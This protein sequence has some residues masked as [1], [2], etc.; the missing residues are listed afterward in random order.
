MTG[1]VGG[2]ADDRQVAEALD[3]G[4]R[5][6]VERVARGGL[7][8]ADAAFAEDHVAVALGHDVLGGQEPL[9][10]RGREAA[11]EHDR[12]ARQADFVE[13]HEVLHV[14]RADLQDVGVARDEFDVAGFHDLGDH[15]QSGLLTG[16]RQVLQT[17]LAESAEG[18]GRGARFEGAAAQHLGAG[19][20][21]GAG[22]RDHVLFV[23]DRAG[24]GHHDHGA[25]ADLDAVDVDDGVFL[26]EFA[27]GQL[28]GPGDRDDLVDAAHAAHLGADVGVA[29]HAHGADHDAFLTR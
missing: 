7:E 21:H 26:L 5:R 12:L 6:E 4:D 11:L 13:Q 18:V 17:F 25:V 14:A 8:G 3:H 15:R 29:D 27:A 10:D 19:G 9:V 1:A 16:R 23:L 28:V 22:G 2:V 20:G 24:P